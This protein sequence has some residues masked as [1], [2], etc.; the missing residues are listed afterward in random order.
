M[1]CS[2]R[3]DATAAD[4]TPARPSTPDEKVEPD[5]TERPNETGAASENLRA[6]EGPA[7]QSATRRSC[8]RPL[9]SSGLCRPRLRLLPWGSDLQKH[10]VL[11][12]SSH[13]YSPDCACVRTASL[14]SEAT[15]RYSYCLSDRRN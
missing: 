10:R 6:A 2:L 15:G 12:S 3:A 4:A 5:G 9:Q 8:P 14:D 13:G 1:L 11:R 7:C